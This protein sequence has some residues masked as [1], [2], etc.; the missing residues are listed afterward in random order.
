MQTVRKAPWQGVAAGPDEERVKPTIAEFWLDKD[1]IKSFKETLKMLEA[2]QALEAVEELKQPVMIIAIDEAHN[3]VHC[4]GGLTAFDRFRAFQDAVQT[5]PLKWKVLLLST[6]SSISNFMPSHRVLPSSARAQAPTLRIRDAFIKFNSVLSPQV[7]LCGRPLWQSTV[8]NY[9]LPEAFGFDNVRKF[10]ACKLLCSSETCTPSRWSPDALLAILCVRLGLRVPLNRVAPALVKS[11]M[12]TV[13]YITSEREPLVIYPSEPMLAEA[14]A[15]LDWTGRKELIE[16]MVGVSSE[17]YFTATGYVG[18]V[19]ARWL[20]LTAVD[21][22]LQDPAKGRLRADDQISKDVDFFEWLSLLNGQTAED[23]KNISLKAALSAREAQSSQQQQQRERS[24]PVMVRM[25]LTHFVHCFRSF[26]ASDDISEGSEGSA[27][28]SLNAED[29]EPLDKYSEPTDFDALAN[30]CFDR[31]CG[32]ITKPGHAGVDL[33]VPVCIQLSETELV[34]HLVPVQVKCIE[35]E[36]TTTDI[37]SVLDKT[38][39]V[40]CDLLPVYL[41]INTFGGC[42]EQTLESDGRIV[43]TLRSCA[44]FQGE[45]S[46]LAPLARNLRP[47]A[48]QLNFR[49][50]QTLPYTK[51]ALDLLMIAEAECWKRR[52]SQVLSSSIHSGSQSLSSSNQPQASSQPQSV[53]M[54]R[55]RKRE[56]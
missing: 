12:A 38:C 10:A 53:T 26:G 22:L 9:S 48:G 4:S 49:L 8:H 54:S 6:N 5:I 50:F 13:M 35:R 24:H 18:E 43:V 42:K 23:L 2:G 33:F 15:D 31:G 55:K 40:Q 1:R 39:F 36:I 32:L 46:K 25:R 3:M 20:M 28:A 37:K 29:S 27:S 21:Q 52:S 30:Y 47:I 7:A 34:Y 16:A 56:S 45:T 14:A 44:Q 41:L 19:T 17:L 51:T 11:H